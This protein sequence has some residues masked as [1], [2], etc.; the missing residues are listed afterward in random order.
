MVDE[1]TRGGALKKCD[2]SSVC[3]FV[4]QAAAFGKAFKRKLNVGWRVAVHAEQLTHGL[5]GNLLID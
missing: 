4:S 2:S 5:I 1:A 3:V